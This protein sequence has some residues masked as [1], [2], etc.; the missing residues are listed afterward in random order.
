[1]KCASALSKVRNTETATRG[2][3]ATIRERMDG[4]AGDLAV[5]FSTPHHADALGAISAAIRAEGLARHVVGC[6]AEAII[7]DGEEVEGVCGLSLWIASM[8]GAQVAPITLAP[9]VES[10]PI[11]N[12]RTPPDD[13]D[14]RALILLG[15]P[16]AFPVDVFLK[17]LN[18]EHIPLRVFGGMASGA[19]APRQN[20]LVLDDDVREDGAVAIQID[21]G[22]KIRGVVSQG[23][24]PIGQH[25]IVTKVERNVIRELGRTPALE[26]LR[27]LFETLDED[28]QDR[29]QQGLH[30]GRVINE[31]QDRFQRGD[32]LVRNVLGADDAGGIAITDV[33]RVGQTV[34]FHVRD[35]VT[36]DE[37]LRMLLEAE[38]RAHPGSK[39]RGALVFTCNGR[40]L[41]LFDEPNHDVA[42]L[43]EI[44]G[45]IPAAGFFAMGEIGPIGNQNFVHGFTACIALFEEDE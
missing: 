10:W 20:R 9:A 36:A 44:A 1:M 30:I 26:T 21:G 25:M 14:S 39:L 45:P 3:L 6:T 42:V 41:R 5:V 27:A 34:Q 37:D 29:V 12:W 7:G 43:D 4:A 19:R 8:P 35:A 13:P 18:D 2:V 38:R 23:C 16:F 31:Y 17:R 24:R 40:G 32:F 22:V 11:D 33:L 15:D 28:D